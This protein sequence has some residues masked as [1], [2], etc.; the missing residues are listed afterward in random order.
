M[1]CSQFVLILALIAAARAQDQSNRIFET[2]TGR[3]HCNGQWTD[4]HFKVMPGTDLLG[5]ND[6]DEPVTAVVNFYFRRSLSHVDAASYVLKGPYDRKTGRFH[7]EPWRW[8]G[9]HPDALEMIGMEGTFETGSRKM[10]AKMLSGKCDAVE[11]V[12]PGEKLAELPAGSSALSTAVLPPS[13]GR[14]EMKTVPTNVTNAF[15]I[16]SADPAFEYWVAAWSEPPGVVHE[17]S[18]IDESVAQLLKDKFMCSESERVTWGAG[19]TKGSAPGRVSVREEYVIECL[20]D[21]KGVWYQPN[22]GGFIT[23]Y[24]L[25][26]PLPRMQIKGV[27]LGGT[28][29]RW[30]FLR[31]SSTQPPPEI[32]IHRWMPLTG[33]G[34]FDGSPEY[35]KQRQAAA[36]PCRAPRS[37]SR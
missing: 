14:P 34:P 15:D 35:M 16:N 12:P 23:H 36:P 8:S 32:Y 6:P 31:K 4:F 37:G 20:G 21:C 25:S 22:V 30:S 19:G 33:K 18:P 1:R 17:G 9:S 2:F 3:F 10:N 5:M 29:F 24:G 13:K 28:A 7:L 27:W 11:M 26:T